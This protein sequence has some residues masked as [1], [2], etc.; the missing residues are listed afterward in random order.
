MF[1]RILQPVRLFPIM[2]Y[3]GISRYSGRKSLLRQELLK[4]A[5][6]TFQSLLRRRPTFL[7][8]SPVHVSLLD[9]FC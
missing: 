7:Y 5:D 2:D 3:R 6:W 8:S 9:V 1:Y 4:G